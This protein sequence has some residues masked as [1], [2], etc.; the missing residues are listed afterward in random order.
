MPSPSW[1]VCCACRIP[2]LSPAAYPLSKSVNRPVHSNSED[3]VP[4]NFPKLES[5]IHWLTLQQRKEE[6]ETRNRHRK[7]PI[8]KYPKFRLFLG[9]VGGAVPL[10]EALG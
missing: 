5:D 1:M 3:K 7:N 6:K 8:N 10:G 4:T 2:L 9:A